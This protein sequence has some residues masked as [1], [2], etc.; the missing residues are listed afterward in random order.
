MLAEKV[1]TF[2]THEPIFEKLMSNQCIRINFKGE[3]KSVDLFQ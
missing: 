1:V 2:Q 3:Y